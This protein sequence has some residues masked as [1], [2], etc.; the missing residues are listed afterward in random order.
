MKLSMKE[1][2]SELI[3]KY[4]VNKA[5]LDDYTKI[6][7]NEKDSI[8]NFMA[9]L[10]VEEY[11]VNGYTAKISN[12]LRQTMNE[13]KLLLKVKELNR[14][15]LV[16]T[17]EYVDSDLLEK[18]IYQGELSAEDLADCMTTKEITTLR[19]SKG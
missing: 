16:K 12:Q 10:K 13:D 1:E 11:T 19:I 15:D 9:I 3:P 18:A 4:A 8:K 7:N 17:K 5:I 6:C 14:P 2:L